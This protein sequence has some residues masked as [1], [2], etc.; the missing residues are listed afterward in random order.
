M[1]TALATLTPPALPP[2]PV[3]SGFAPRPTPSSRR[4][5]RTATRAPPFRC[6]ARSGSSYPGSLRHVRERGPRHSP[7]PGAVGP[8][9]RLCVGFGGGTAGGVGGQPAAPPWQPRAA[10]GAEPGSAQVGGR[11]AEPRREVRGCGRSGRG[12]P[13]CRRPHRAGPPVRAGEAGG[14]AA[15]KWL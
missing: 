4:S 1:Q 14:A 9:G 12:A 2:P 3:P 6:G 8:A 5:S 15:F 13:R 11:R 10:G 7:P